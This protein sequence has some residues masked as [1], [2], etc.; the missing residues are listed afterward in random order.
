MLLVHPMMRRTVN[1]QRWSRLWLLSVLIV[2]QVFSIGT[3]GDAQRAEGVGKVTALE[4]SATVQRKGT[5]APQ[6]IRAQ[7]LVYPQDVI[8]TQSASKLRVTF[9]DDTLVSIGEKSTLEVTEF[10]YAPQQQRQTSVLTMS[11]G[12]LRA[13]ARELLPQSTFEVATPTATAAIRGTDFM[14]EITSEAS[15]IVALEGSVAV[16]GT[17]TLFRPPVTLNVGMGTTVRR[18]EAPSAP[19]KWGE[20]RIEA[21]RRATTIR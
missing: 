16:S 10:V 1:M 6:P 19:T 5:S 11:V 2:V 8:R 12:M 21:L 3:A 14:A 7:S 9:V 18:N 20:A 17:D 4:G 15:S 13:I